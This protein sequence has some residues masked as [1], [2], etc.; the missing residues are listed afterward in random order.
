[1]NYSEHYER[2]IAR[3]RDRVLEGYVERHHVIPKCMGGSNSKV[4]LVQLTPEEHYVAHQLLHK[5]H[6]DV[7]GLAIAVF[8]MT[9]NPH[10]HRRNKLYGWVRKVHAQAVSDQSIARWKDPEYR[11]KHSLAMEEVR[12]R[13]GYREQFS[14]LFK[15]RVKS[16]EEIAKFVASKT[17]MKYKTMSAESR[18]NMAAARRKTWEERR[19]NGTANE[20]GAKTRATRI[21]NGTYSFTA[22]HRAAIGKAQRGK[23]ISDEQRAKIS[24]K[25]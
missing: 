11:E 3:A 4:N 19:A 6:T 5:M 20:I 21:K 18:A 23:A 8:G 2:L 24:T 14:V 10:G 1:M 22:E 25:T 17:G 13:P 15:G 12:S 9:T 16:P 7:R